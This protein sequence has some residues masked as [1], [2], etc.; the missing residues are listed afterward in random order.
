MPKLSIIIPMYNESRYVARCLDSL[1]LQ[2]FQ[3]FELILIDDGSTDNSVEIVQWYKERFND[4]L[5]I[6]HQEH[7]WPGKARNRWASVAKGD[8]LIFVDADMVFD[9]DYLLFLT[10]PILDSAVKWTYHGTELV[11]NINNPIAR[12]WSIVRLQDQEGNKSGVF[13][14][15]LKKDFIDSGWFDP[16]KW[17]FDD[18]LSEAIWL[19]YC[20]AKA[21]CYHNN[22]ETLVE[23]YEHSQRVGKSL[24][25][26]GQIKN[27]SLKYKMRIGWFIIV[28]LVILIIFRNNLAFVILMAIIWLLLLIFTK[29]IERSF[30]EKYLSHLIYVP[31]VMIARWLGYMVGGMRYLFTKK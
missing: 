28:L 2:S 25:Q 17:Y 15:T 12:A 21:I 6:L 23:W 24:M 18:N 14:A 22:P 5:T 1:L 7:W 4:N 11:A 8:I 30:K 10:K 13:R 3:D 9:V 20:V 27:Y 26:S 16:S 19:S 29:A 31:L